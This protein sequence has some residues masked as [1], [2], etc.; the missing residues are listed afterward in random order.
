M[1]EQK[2]N[3]R[4]A[5]SQASS[6][7]N[8]NWP[9]PVPPAPSNPLLGANLGTSE[10]QTYKTLPLTLPGRHQRRPAD[11]AALER[12]GRKDGSHPEPRATR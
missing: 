2:H 4:A 8:P 11:L 6:N 9:S 5:I 10:A 3:K 12:P 7:S 1:L